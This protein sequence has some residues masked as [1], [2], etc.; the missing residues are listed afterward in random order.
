M[1]GTVTVAGSLCIIAMETWVILSDHFGA[2]RYKL[3]RNCIFICTPDLEEKQKMAT[4]VTEQPGGTRPRI[5][6]GEQTRSIK[7]PKEY[8]KQ[9]YTNTRTII[10][11]FDRQELCDPHRVPPYEKWCL[12]Q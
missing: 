10:S 2:D 1:L 11:R 9:R 3:L 12:A 7:N 5:T 4:A 8:M 6:D